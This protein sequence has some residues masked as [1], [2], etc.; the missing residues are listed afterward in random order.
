M[1]YRKKPVEI[2]AFQLGIDPMPK[3]FMMDERVTWGNE[4]ETVSPFQHES[5]TLYCLIETLEGTMRGNYKDYILKGVQGE[6][7]PCKP[8]IFETTYEKCEKENKYE[9]HYTCE[10]CFWNDVES[11]DPCEKCGRYYCEDCGVPD[12]E[13]C[14]DCKQGSTQQN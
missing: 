6:I 14:H 10:C 2:E 5:E 11:D 8:D 4:K 12:E 9:E 1:K 13:I 7:Y 3:W